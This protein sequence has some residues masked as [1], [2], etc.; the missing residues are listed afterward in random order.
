MLRQ[1]YRKN[2]QDPQSI[3][4]G[5][6]NTQK[7]YNLVGQPLKNTPVIHVGGS[8]GKGSVCY[9]LAETLRQN[10]F[11]TGLFV[12]PHISSYRERIQVNAQV[13][14]VGTMAT[15][16]PKLLSVCEKE[17]INASFFELTT[18]L[19]LL[20]FDRACCDAVVLEVGLGG[21]LDATN[22]I[23]NP[24]LS[25]ITNI[26]LEHTRILGKT[27]PE[28]AYAKAGI[29][30]QGCPLLL[31]FGSKAFLQLS[32]LDQPNLSAT[33]PASAAAEG[34]RQ[35]SEESIEVIQVMH[36]EAQRVGASSVTHVADY[37]QD[38]KYLAGKTKNIDLMNGDIAV[39]A[40]RLIERDTTKIPGSDTHERNVQRFRR[41][42]ASKAANF[43]VAYD[44]R[45]PCRFQ[46]ITIKSTRGGSAVDVILDVAHTH[47]AIASLCEKV[48]EMNSPDVHVVIG[49]CA[50][51]NVR[52]CIEHVTSLVGPGKHRSNVHCVSSA[53]K[54]MNSVKTLKEIV[55][56]V[57]GDTSAAG[58]DWARIGSGSTATNADRDEEKEIRI[59]LRQAIDKASATTK[60]VAVTT[61]ESG[62]KR[63]VVLVCGSAFIMASVREEIGING[64]PRDPLQ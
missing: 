52:K 51:K 21:R 3:Q 35:I 55:L 23:P 63:P 54:R 45:P 17:K 22:V 37:L 64:P 20:A 38:R 42:L 27:L 48:R 11:K 40:L 33:S 41:N 5:L 60:V 12:S 26:Q 56:E 53:Q 43:G 46:T 30:K 34:A 8:T 4:M 19:A 15:I 10:G 50:D 31:G 47:D 7:L 62:V 18:I 59:A 2:L 36:D 49:M 44:V 32:N 16:L 61:E 14:D 57:A 1:L 13:M 24:I 25:I 39:T 6:S 29:A 58:A 28:I 9:K